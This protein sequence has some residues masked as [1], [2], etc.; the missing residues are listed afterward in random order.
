[1]AVIAAGLR[2]A[3]SGGTDQYSCGLFFGYGLCSYGPGRLRAAVSGGAGSALIPAPGGYA[4]ACL[5][6]IAQGRQSVAAAMMAFPTA[7][8][9]SKLAVH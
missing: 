6:A 3:V 2:A 8:G 1:M 7:V 4:A 9:R 5:S